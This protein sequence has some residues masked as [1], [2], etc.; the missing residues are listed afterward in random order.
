MRRALL[1]LYWLACLC[2][3][4]GL[5]MLLD[6]CGKSPPTPN[7]VSPCGVRVF[8]TSDAEGFAFAEVRALSAF[9]NIEP[10]LCQR[11]HNW[12]ISILPPG[13]LGDRAGQTLTDLLGIQLVSDDW[14]RSAYSH[15]L[16]HMIDYPRIDYAHA[17]WG[18][19]DWAAIAEANQ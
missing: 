12:T 3:G 15:E 18:D 9:R 10:R 17:S 11:L 16:R 5:A 14:R 4:F 6:G 8:G 7:F 13:S 1:S 19:E 2:L